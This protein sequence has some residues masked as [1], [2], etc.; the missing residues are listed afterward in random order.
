MKP[1]LGQR[2]CRKE[3]KQVEARDFYD[4]LG[5]DYDVM[6][7]WKERLR[8]E[9][10]FLLGVARDTGAS[11][12][13]DAA[14]GTGMHAVMLAEGGLR[15]AGVDLSPAMIERARENAQRAGVSVDFRVAAFGELPPSF[16]GQF[17][18]VLC[19]GNSLPHILDDDSLRRALRDFSRVMS[20]RGTLVIQNRNYDRVLKEKVR[21]MPVTSRA[22]GADE[23]L[24][25]RITD[26]PREEK[27]RVEF[28]IVCLKRRD[29][30]WTQS[31][32][33]TPLRALRRQVLQDTLRECGFPRVQA[34]GG[35]D[36]SPFDETRSADLLVTASKNAAGSGS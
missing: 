33:S 4:E 29:G 14:C 26:F 8:R 30:A 21:F 19:L 2:E 17:D 3:A 11:S 12:V 6:V 7:S 36:L 9:A 5:S 27:D 34:L 35:F 20:P 16:A 15:C 25:V 13:L 22:Q 1:G 28:T 10:G 23:T 18:L 31:V 24:F 32:L